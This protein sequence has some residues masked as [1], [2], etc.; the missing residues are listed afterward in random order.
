[1]NTANNVALTLYDIY[2][3]DA[4]E[5]YLGF[6]KVAEDDEFEDDEE[7]EEEEDDWEDGDGEEESSEEESVEEPTNKIAKK[8]NSK[9]K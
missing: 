8:D 7:E 1:M 3:H 6:W 5:N 9:A 4:L 2:C